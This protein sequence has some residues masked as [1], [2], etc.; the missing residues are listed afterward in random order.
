[1]ITTLSVIAV[2]VLSVL[3]AISYRRGTTWR[4]LAIEQRARGE[5]LE[6]EVEAASKMVGEAN[7]A[8]AQAEQARKAATAARDAASGQLDTSESDVAALEARIAALAGEKARLEDE[9]AVA[10]QTVRADGQ[11]DTALRQCV[12][13][14][15]AWLDGAPDDG[16]VTSW[17]LWAAEADQWEAGCDQAMTLSGS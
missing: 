7:A 6:Q 17:R 11:T 3:T 4:D 13:A 9:L 1:M 16:E 15:T 8:V 10:G 5:V 12:I 2:V 14:I